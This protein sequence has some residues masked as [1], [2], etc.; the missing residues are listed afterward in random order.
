MSNLITFLQLGTA[1]SSLL[2]RYCQSKEGDWV[3]NIEE[4]KKILCDKDSYAFFR[5]VLPV[6]TVVE[7]TSMGNKVLP[8][9]DKVLALLLSLQAMEERE[10][11]YGRFVSIADTLAIF[12]KEFLAIYNPANFLQK[13]I[14]NG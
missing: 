11:S 6:L 8:W 9:M 13:V 3:R 1:A 4:V 5:I 10:R 12:Y 2:D 14:D 7:E